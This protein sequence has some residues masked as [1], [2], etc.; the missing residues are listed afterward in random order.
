MAGTRKIEPPGAIRVKRSDYVTKSGSFSFQ[1]RDARFMSTHLLAH[2]P[3][4]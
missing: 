4:L 3:Y 1:K 2:D